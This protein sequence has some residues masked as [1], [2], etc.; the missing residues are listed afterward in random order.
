M[1]TPAGFSDAFEPCCDVHPVTKNVIALDQ[2]VA[3]M[4]ADAPFQS[5][6]VGNCGI[7]LRCQL[8]QRQSAFDGN[9]RNELDQDPVAGGLNDPAMLNDE[10]IGSGAMLAQCLRSARL[11]KP[12]QPTV[13]DAIRARIAARRRTGGMEGALD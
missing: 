1:Q 7:A 10:R 3:E 9:D 13:T 5:A 4:D 11:I 12:H 2:H 6:L 8:L